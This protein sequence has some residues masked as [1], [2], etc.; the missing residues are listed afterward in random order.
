M[1]VL[2]RNPF[3]P[4]RHFETDALVDTGASCICIS[5]RLA[6]ELGLTK[7]GE[8][9][10]I[11]VGADHPATEYAGL[12]NVPELDFER[13][14][15]MYAPA[16]V[17]AT[18]SVLLGRSFLEHFVYTYHGPSGTFQFHNAAQEAAQEH[19]FEE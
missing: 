14:L 17:H 6:T 10:M 1:R 11:A 19:D 5:R 12:L 4:S 13:F 16:G 8:T 3:E 7:T 18:P 15:P 2:L 9:R